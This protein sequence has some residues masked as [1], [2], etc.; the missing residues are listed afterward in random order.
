[1]APHASRGAAAARAEPDP[2][3][4]KHEPVKGPHPGY[5][6]I[7]SQYISEQKL[8]QMQREMKCDPAREDTYRLQ[9]VQLIDSIRQSLQLYAFSPPSSSSLRGWIVDT[10]AECRPVK[11]F[12]T[13][14]TYYHKF[15]LYFRDTEYAYPDAAVA[16][17]FVACK[18]D[19]TLKKS[20]ELLCTQ[21][22]LAHR[23]LGSVTSQDDKVRIA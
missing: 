15:R 20:R 11:T 17:L 22:N 14:C 4:E 6:S 12:D 18:A 5:L 10:D 3:T 2:P 19:D 1:M 7:A 21:H 23:G 9:G 16:S 13:A 8:R